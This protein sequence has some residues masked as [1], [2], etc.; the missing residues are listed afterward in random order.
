MARRVRLPLSVIEDVNLMLFTA[1]EHG[2]RHIALQP[3]VDGIEIK[4]LKPDG[5]EYHE[6]LALSYED[7]VR[8]LREMS[9]R[10][11]RV[12]VDMGGHRWNVDATV[13]SARRPD[14]VFVHMRPVD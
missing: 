1:W 7:T 9:A 2:A 12:R 8:R 11:G 3:E 4:Y 6:R 5:A 10:L 14:R 13:P